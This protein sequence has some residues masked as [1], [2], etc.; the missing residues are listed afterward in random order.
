[1]PTA[2]RAFVSS[3]IIIMSIGWRLEEVKGELKG[4]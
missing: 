3:I 2:I 4:S 1:M